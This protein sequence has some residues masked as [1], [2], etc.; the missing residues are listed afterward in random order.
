MR[1]LTSFFSKKPYGLSVKLITMIVLCS[2]LFAFLATALQVYYSFNQ[3]IEKIDKDVGYIE[4]SYIP[5]LTLSLYKFNLDQVVKQLEG[6]AKLQGIEYLEVA[7][8][9]LKVNNKL[10]V[11]SNIANPDM[12][13]KYDLVYTTPFQKNISVGKLSIFISYKEIYTR[14]FKDV[15]IIL[16]SNMMKTILVSLC[17]VVIFYYVVIRHLYAISDYTRRIDQSGFG[18]PLSL[19]RSELMSGKKDEIDSVV[20]SINMMC[21]GLQKE[22]NRLKQMQEV[23]AEAKEK[24]EASDQAK[25]VFIANMSHELRTPLNAIIGFSDLILLKG[26][27]YSRSFK[28]DLI[29]NISKSGKH[30]LKIVNDLLNVSMIELGKTNIDYS[31]FNLA[32]LLTGLIDNYNHIANEGDISLEK[33]LVDIDNLLI[34]ADSVK[35]QQIVTNLLANAIKFTSQ[36]GRVGIKAAKSNKGIT[37][38]VWD[39]GI[40]IAENDLEDIFVPFS[41]V[42]DTLNRKFGGVGIGLGICKKYAQ[43]HGGKIWVKSKLGE[44]SSF[45]VFIPSS[46]KLHE[47]KQTEAPLQSGKAESNEDI[48]YLIIEDDAA[49]VKLVKDVL[50]NNKSSFIEAFTG[51]R[52]LEL[53]EQESPDIILLDI[54]LPDISG[55]EVFKKL[56]DNLKTKGIPVIAISA[57]ATE[58]HRLLFSQLG[59]KGYIVKPIDVGSF[60]KQIQSL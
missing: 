1:F 60:V 40:G 5:S 15:I 8:S 55:L 12:V 36:G 33:D 58:K 56:Q 31:E 51:K 19:G 28:H 54:G 46:L 35:I 41:Q 32:K 49:S 57:Y 52:G 25:T 16:A 2:T 21:S 23:L 10:S 44:G 18:P 13:K 39:T 11:G 9:S 47:V 45:F 59:F 53:A 6:I 30:L 34:N 22:Q 48:K 43:L 20:N 42:E 17:M 27:S 14:M 29:D 7:V 24:A 38:T 37:I 4:D 50:K 3:D 26:E